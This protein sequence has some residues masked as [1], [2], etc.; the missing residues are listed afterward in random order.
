MAASR[1]R[2]RVV[3]L[4]ALKLG[5][6]LTAVPALR[7]VRRH[8]PDHHLA[9]AAPA[10]LAE[11]LHLAG[12]ADEV[13]NTRGLGPLDHPSLQRA[14]LALNLHGRGPQSSRHL[15]R[16][17]PGRLVAFA[18]P[19]VPATAGGPRWREHEHEVVRWCRL[20]R[21]TGIAADPGDLHLPAPDTE[22]LPGATGAILLHPGASAP[23]RRWPAHRW[24]A[25]ARH[26][27][28]E[29]HRIILTGDDAETGLARRIAEACRP[30]TAQ[31]WTGRTSLMQLFATVARARLVVSGDTGV[32][33]VATAYK[34]PS[35]VLFGPVPPYRWGP[36]VGGPHTVV[37]KGYGGPGDPHGHEP[38]PNLLAITVDQVIEAV[39]ARL[40]Q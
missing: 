21:E 28:S 33:H 6:V 14:D 20:L 17:R 19:E 26:L 13:V 15:A 18:H 27:A 32:A 37:W 39:E 10:W 5:D 23:A 2:P 11:V 1:S 12:A 24:A 30:W 16:S 7:A 9:V 29:G 4:R 22:P 8:L 31:V 40:R 35:V 3:A 38:D 25:V 36:P 34:T